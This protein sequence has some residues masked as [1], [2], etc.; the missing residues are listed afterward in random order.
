MKW[1]VFYTFPSR[2][3]LGWNHWYDAS[4]KAEGEEQTEAAFLE[5]CKTA[6]ASTQGMHYIVTAHNREKGL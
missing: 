2:G 6:F 3:W 5:W 4:Y 1:T